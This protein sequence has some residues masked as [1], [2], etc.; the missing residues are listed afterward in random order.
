M[1][2]K[3][4]E[5]AAG[6]VV[7][8]GEVAASEQQPSETKPDSDDVCTFPGSVVSRCWSS[9]CDDVKGWCIACH[10][11]RSSSH[12]KRGKFT[13]QSA[14]KPY[15]RQRVQWGGAGA[16][17]ETSSIQD[18]ESTTVPMFILASCDARRQMFQLY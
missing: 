3:K 9:G 17:V 12:S 8:F 15:A 13:T 16:A 7:A 10:A 1:N 14:Q 18:R 11:P 4:G 2:N 5:G 6:T